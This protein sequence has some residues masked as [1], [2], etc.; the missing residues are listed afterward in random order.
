MALRMASLGRDRHSGSWKARKAIPVALRGAYA[1][2]Y[3]RGWE[4]K[5]V[6][7]ASHSEAQARAAFAEW[8][9]DIEAR[10]S[11][12]SALARGEGADLTQRVV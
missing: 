2:A 11:V 8:L 7:P 3:G 10:V 5:F 9:S 1:H 6:A 12:I 4:E